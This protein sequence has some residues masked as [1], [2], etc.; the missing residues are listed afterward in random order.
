MKTAGALACMA[1]LPFVVFA[2][3]LPLRRAVED[4]TVVSRADPPIRIRIADA[5]GYAGAQRFVLRETADAEQHFFVQCDERKT[6]QRLYWIQFEQLLPGKKG[7]YDY[8]GGASLRLGELEFLGHVRQYA[9]PPDPTSDRKR[10]YDYL[11]QAGYTVPENATRVRLVHV[12]K[13]N[14]RQEVMIIYLEG[15][16]G[17]AK[18][19]ES[20][21]ILERAK[22]GLTIL[23]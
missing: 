22:A 23:R 17:G 5:Y 3:T 16:L 13:D 8:E 11:E 20:P 21:E 2:G 9:D 6:V 19:G 10:A 1:A 7:E 4:H 14:R 18:T 12:P 15:A